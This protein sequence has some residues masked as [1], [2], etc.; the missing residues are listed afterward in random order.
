MPKAIPDVNRSIFDCLGG[1]SSEPVNNLT[2]KEET[3]IANE[4][5]SCSE[6]NRTGE[7]KA[8]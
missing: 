4:V 2:G 7:I 8:S 5:S 1:K 3:E 6:R